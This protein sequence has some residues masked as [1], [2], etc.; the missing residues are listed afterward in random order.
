[1]I[2]WLKAIYQ[3]SKITSLA[4]NLSLLYLPFNLYQKGPETSKQNFSIFHNK[5]YWNEIRKYEQLI[6]LK[7]LLRELSYWMRNNYIFMTIPR[8]LS[9]CQQTL[10][11]NHWRFPYLL[12][13]EPPIPCSAPKSSCPLC[14]LCPTLPLWRLVD[15]F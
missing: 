3:I 1:M 11:K 15:I 10:L 9:A 12:L 2:K 4:N 14:P 5:L 13:K 6:W 8:L 7:Q